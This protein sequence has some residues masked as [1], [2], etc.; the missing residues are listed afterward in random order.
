MFKT[1]QIKTQTLGDKL[2]NARESKRMALWQASKKIKIPISYLKCL[3]E[4]NYKELPANVYIAAYLKK[5]AEILDLDIDE[6]SEQFKTESG[7]TE[8]LSKSSKTSKSPSYFLKKR[9]PFIVTP[10]KLSL[11]LGI[12]AVSLI[13][14]YFWHQLSYLIYPPNIEIAQ[15]ASD[16]TTPEEFLEISGQTKPDV[17]LTINGKEVYV[18]NKG[19]FQSVVSLKLGLNI[20]KIEARDR[21]GKTNT[22]IRKVMVIK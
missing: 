12:I 19:F 20:F 14:G 2:K 9:P 1:K 17:Y 11:V 10:K 16:F 6:I 22:V 21:F 8:N 18:D 15:P 5:Y 4:G 7:I 3:E 13:F